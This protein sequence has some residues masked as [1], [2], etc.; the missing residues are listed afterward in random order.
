MNRLYCRTFS[1]PIV[2]T[3]LVL[4]CF[5]SDP[6]P[7]TK[8]SHFNS[9]FH[10][11]IRLIKSTHAGA[12]Y[13]T[14]RVQTCMNGA[15]SWFLRRRSGQVSRTGSTPGRISSSYVIKMTQSAYTSII[16]H[17]NAPKRYAL[18]VEFLLQD[19]LEQDIRI[20]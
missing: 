12:I 20:G 13:S 4:H 14:I 9:L 6:D 18:S 10:S 11:S 19:N 17:S 3:I 5:A 15:L 1:S 16:A 7:D 8:K 2:R